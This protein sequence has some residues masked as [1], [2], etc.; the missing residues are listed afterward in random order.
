MVFIVGVTILSAILCPILPEIRKDILDYETKKE[1]VKWGFI[2]SLLGALLGVSVGMLFSLLLLVPIE[3]TGV[4]VS[5]TEE[6]PL[7]AVKNH[8]YVTARSNTNNAQTYS[9]VLENEK[10]KH[11]ESITSDDVYIVESDDVPSLVIH[12]SEI[13]PRYD[14]FLI[15]KSDPHIDYY[16]FTVPEGSVTYEYDIDLK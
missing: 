13:D 11:I 9:Y 3:A 16:T 14:W 7:Y 2:Y 1:K 15:A 5:Y 4:R 10:G 6:Y 12:K 8:S